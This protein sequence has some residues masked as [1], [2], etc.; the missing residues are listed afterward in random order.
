MGKTPQR[1]LELTERPSI[2]WLSIVFGYGPML[3]FAAGALAAWSFA[4]AIRAE[5]VLLTVIWASSI[6]AF[7]SGVRRGL[8]FRTE[9]GPAP[10]QI[11]AMFFT[12]VLS[13][14]ALVTGVHGLAAAAVVLLL[15]GFAAILV[16]DPIAARKGRAPLFFARLRPPQ[17]SIAVASLAVLLANLLLL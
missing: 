8:S 13:L 12:F 10:G 11:I 14:A 16:L 9:G 15:V 7:L 3:P 4:G 5:A 2:P 1:S 6:L 17:L